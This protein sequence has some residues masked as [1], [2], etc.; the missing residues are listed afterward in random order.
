M[1]QQL[2]KPLL[3]G[4]FRDQEA[5]KKFQEMQ[6]EKRRENLLK[7]Q[8]FIK[9]GL[10]NDWLNR[11]FDIEDGEFVCEDF[12]EI[13]SFLILESLEQLRTELNYGNWSINQG[14]IFGDFAFINQ[15]NGGKEWAVFKYI[16]EENRA[17]QF[18][19]WTGFAVDFSEFKKIQKAT[20]EQLKNLEWD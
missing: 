14:F 2:I 15:I 19:S 6:K 9:S 4:L 12:L 3:E 10:G 1:N 16:K 7:I 13:N 5:W 17:F 18:E 8:A 20:N 11:S